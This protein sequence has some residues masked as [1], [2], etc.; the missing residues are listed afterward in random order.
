MWAQSHSSQSASRS[1]VSHSLQLYGLYCPGNSPGQNTGV[2]SLSLLQGIFPTQGLNPGLPH[3]RWNLY[4]LSH[5]GSPYLGRSP[6]YF[7]GCQSLTKVWSDKHT[8]VREVSEPTKKGSSPEKHCGC[9]HPLSFPLHSAVFDKAG[10]SRHPY[11]AWTRNETSCLRAL[12]PTRDAPP[13]KSCRSPVASAAA[14]RAAANPLLSLWLFCTFYSYKDLICSHWKIMFNDM[15]NLSQYV[16]R[17]KGGYKAI[18]N[19][20]LFL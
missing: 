14:G 15:R 10:L 20:I 11:G 7:Y 9:S 8:Y 18:Y 19:V 5:K 2:G 4:Q 13:P 12:E 16:A 6:L 3:C 1:V 17:K